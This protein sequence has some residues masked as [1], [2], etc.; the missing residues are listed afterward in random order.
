MYIEFEDVNVGN[1]WGA[2]IPRFKSSLSANKIEAGLAFV[3]RLT[4]LL[5]IR[6][7]KGM[8]LA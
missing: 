3:R 2:K 4:E 1:R 8:H 6:W 7:T 5:M